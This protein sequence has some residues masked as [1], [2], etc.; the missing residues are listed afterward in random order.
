MNEDAKAQSR[1]HLSLKGEKKLLE[2]GEQRSIMLT[3]REQ[4]LEGRRRLRGISSS[5][6]RRSK[7]EFLL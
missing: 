6:S 2:K 5:G 1:Q 7:T 4:T 3:A